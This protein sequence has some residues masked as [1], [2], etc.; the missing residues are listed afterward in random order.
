MADFKT[1]LKEAKT[2]ADIFEV[3][4][5]VVLKTINKS[6]AGLMLGIA[7]L[8]NHPQGFLADSLPLALMS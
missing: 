1:K 6:R 7:D 4:K 2:F 8:G 3:V 5:E